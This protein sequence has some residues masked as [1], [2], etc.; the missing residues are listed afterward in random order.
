MKKNYKNIGTILL[1]VTSVCA[2]ALL[3]SQQVAIHRADAIMHPTLAHGWFRFAAR[4][5][6]WGNNEFKP[7]WMIRYT[8]Q[9]TEVDFPPDVQVSFGGRVIST[10]A[11]NLLDKIA[12][13]ED[14]GD[15][16]K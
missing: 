11:S 16:I 4:P 9:A 10:T 2:I 7:R 6:L 8:H 13:N 15:Q 12:V 3:V 5:V 14:N 1:G